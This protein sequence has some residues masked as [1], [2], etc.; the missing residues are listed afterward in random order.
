MSHACPGRG[1]LLSDLLLARLALLLV[2][3][4]GRSG[5][6]A[7][8][9]K[10]EGRPKGAAPLVS[11]AGAE[12][13]KARDRKDGQEQVGPP[14]LPEPGSRPPTSSQLVRGH[15]G[16]SKSPEVGC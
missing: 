16:P 12:E 4:D 9:E 10:A 5:S 3:V 14:S 2:Q 8:S 15:W 13:R 1:Q 11:A 7:A 6:R